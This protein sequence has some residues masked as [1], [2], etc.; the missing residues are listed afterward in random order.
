ME[1]GGT[2]SRTRNARPS[3]F[4]TASIWNIYAKHQVQHVGRR[5]GGGGAPGPDFSAYFCPR[6][7]KRPRHTLTAELPEA[8]KHVYLFMSCVYVFLHTPANSSPWGRACIRISAPE[9]LDYLVS[10]ER[11][12]QAHNPLQHRQPQQ[13]NY[14][15]MHRKCRTLESKREFVWV[16]SLLSQKCFK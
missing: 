15:F 8:R 5:T 3:H 9:T 16:A 12:N 2:L 10:N 4:L 7:G 1:H 11:G 13:H 6:W 14:C